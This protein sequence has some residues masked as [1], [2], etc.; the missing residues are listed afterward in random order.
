MSLKM[1]MSDNSLQQRR[2]WFRFF[3]E[4][5]IEFL[6]VTRV[7][8]LLLLV[9]LIILREM[10]RPLV[11]VALAGVLWLDYVLM[12][13]WAVQL[14]IDLES[15]W[16]Q[17]PPPADE[18]RRRRIRAGLVACLP[19][20][21]AL[22]IL[23]PWTRFVLP[24]EAARVAVRLVMDPVLCVLFVILLVVGQ[25][26]LQRINL[27]PA[28]WTLLLLIPV[29]HFFAMHRLLVGLGAR[30]QRREHESEESSVKDAGPSGVVI[31]ADATW[32]LSILPWGIVILLTFSGGG[33]PSEA[34]YS[35]S[36]IC[37]ILLAGL[38]AVSNLAA[39]ENVQRRFV[40]LIRKP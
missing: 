24:N 34:P 32:F 17:P 37:G 2:K 7:L 29:V 10:Q 3:P 39:M 15:L 1:P 28:R 22:L 8:A 33:W 18:L 40:A 11:L 35:F 6:L 14:T 4:G 16:K 23:A 38:F 19:S 20:V 9:S 27:G 25:R 36:P 5:S 31:F 30:L 12:I 26:T 13:W 21:A